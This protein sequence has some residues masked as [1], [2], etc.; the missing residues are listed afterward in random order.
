M[1]IITQ[2]IQSS[3][4]NN[5]PYVVYSLLPFDE[6]SYPNIA[7]ATNRKYCNGI[8]VFLYKKIIRLA[9][10]LKFKTLINNV[11]K[12]RETFLRSRLYELLNSDEKFIID[13]FLKNF[14]NGKFLLMSMNTVDDFKSKKIS[15]KDYIDEFNV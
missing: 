1:R 6:V 8:N 13:Q 9:H 3:L 11:D 12:E 7:T 4:R 15:K 5:L 10:F 14:D 2:N